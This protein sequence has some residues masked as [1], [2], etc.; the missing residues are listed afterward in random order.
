MTLFFSNDW[1]I[2][3]LLAR[4]QYPPSPMKAGER[5]GVGVVL[6]GMAGFDSKRGEGYFQPHADRYIQ[7]LKLYKQGHI[8]KIFVTGGQA[9]AFP[10]HDLRESDFIVEN[11]LAM[12]VPKEDVLHERDSRNTIE[13]AA[14]TGRIMDSL[15]MRE[16]YVLITSAYHMPRALMIFNKRGIPVRP[17]PCDYF[18]K[19]SGTELSW[20][21][22]I[23]DTGAFSY[24]VDY[25]KEIV[26]ILYLKLKGY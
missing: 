5:Y 22:L 20:Q 24:W 25:L 21:S 6:G 15:Q 16:P 9:S 7:A 26:G 1:V 18:V 12:G 11:L 17:F 23:P 10:K 13:N 14:F 8:G 2:K 3:N 19:P 4:H